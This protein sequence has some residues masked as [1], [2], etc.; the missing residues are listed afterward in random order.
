MSFRGQSPSASA[1][2]LTPTLGHAVRNRC[3]SLFKAMAATEAHRQRPWSAPASW[4][5]IQRC[6]IRGGGTS[7]RTT[8]VQLVVRASR[9][10]AAPG[11]QRVVVRGACRFGASSSSRTTRTFQQPEFMAGRHNTGMA[12]VIKSSASREQN[13][14]PNPAVNRTPCGSPRLALISFW[15][16]RGLPQG[17]G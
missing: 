16:K 13:A 10:S 2:S 14:W 12:S 5:P 1:V 4:P 6:A 3:A 15:A 9:G 7:T 8:A 11:S 17:A